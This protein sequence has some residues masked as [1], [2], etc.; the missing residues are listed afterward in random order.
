M[1]V[2]STTEFLAV[3]VD[4]LKAFSAPLCRRLVE[5]IDK[6]RDDSVSKE[7]LARWLRISGERAG[8]EETRR[9]FL[10]EDTDKDGRLSFKEFHEGSKS[11]GQCVGGGVWV[12]EHWSVCGW[13][14][15]V[16][17]SHMFPC[18]G[19]SSHQ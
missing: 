2:W 19:Y 7:E 5:A 8:K 12:E 16:L 11:T 9:T 18:V 3:E 6:D 1:W 10:R 4:T 13:G 15:E 17:A 14:E